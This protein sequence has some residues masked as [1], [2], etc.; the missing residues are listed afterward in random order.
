MDAM[1][2]FAKNFLTA[3]GPDIVSGEVNFCKE[4]SATELLGGQAFRKFEFALDRARAIAD[5]ANFLDNLDEQKLLTELDDFDVGQAADFPSW[6]SY[7][8]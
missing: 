7:L 5:L 3:L 4:T 2:A 1:W 6:A 8:S